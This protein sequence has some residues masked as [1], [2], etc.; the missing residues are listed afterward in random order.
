MQETIPTQG[1]KVA[2]RLALAVDIAA[3]E[4]HLIV[5]GPAVKRVGQRGDKRSIGSGNKR[6][7][8]WNDLEHVIPFIAEK[9]VARL[10]VQASREHIVAGTAENPVF[11]AAAGKHVIAGT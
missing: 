3:K 6:Q 2:H 9:Q 4:K 1:N 7:A 11:S 8:I 10:T 5:T